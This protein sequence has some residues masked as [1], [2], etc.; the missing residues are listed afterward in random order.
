MK[1]CVE[2]T[3]DTET[4]D[5]H[6]MECPPREEMT[7]AEGM[8]EGGEMQDFQDMESAMKYA[9]TLLTGETRQS[10]DEARQSVMAGYNR[11]GNRPMM[12]GRM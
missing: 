4:G 3:I 6:V 2:I 9:A 5:L 12:G 8:A 1:K 7:E 10:P 11:A